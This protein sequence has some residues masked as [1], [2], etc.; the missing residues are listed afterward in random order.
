MISHSTHDGLILILRDRMVA[1]PLLLKN[2]VMNKLLLSTWVALWYFCKVL[3]VC[4]RRYTQVT[5]KYTFSWT[6]KCSYYE[7]KR[8]LK[9][10]CERLSVDHTVWLYQWSMSIVLILEQHILL[11]ISKGYF[12]YLM[13]TAKNLHR[14]LYPQ[15]S[16]HSQLHNSLKIHETQLHTYNL[17]W[18]LNCV[19][20]VLNS[21]FLS[22]CPAPLVQGC[23]R[24]G[25]QAEVDS[26][27][28]TSG[29]IS[30]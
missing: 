18:M 26:H 4:K 16:D 7:M 3:Q 19:I 14:A 5:F 30:K 2:S 24:W 1:S 10:L 29:H 8:E 15:F 27:K 6:T 9:H 13:K 17:N 11:S 23:L 20:L 25:P 28:P 22:K 21:T 12:N